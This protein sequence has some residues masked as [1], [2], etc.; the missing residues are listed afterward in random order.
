M[1]Q[2]LYPLGDYNTS[3]ILEMVDA[4]REAKSFAE[5]E[6]MDE[7]LVLFRRPDAAPSPAEFVRAIPPA[8]AP[9]MVPDAFV[10]AVGLLLAQNL[11][12]PQL[13]AIGAEG[14][15]YLREAIKMNLEIAARENP[16]D[17]ELKARKDYV[18][19]SPAWQ[20]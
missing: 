16:N 14:D 19:W 9:F 11:T 18:D 2:N 3:Q 4:V 7:K 10:G 8:E 12:M 13:E 17:P 5:S 15:P 1:T 20:L 6:A